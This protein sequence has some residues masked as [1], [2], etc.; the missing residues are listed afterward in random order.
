MTNP[1]LPYLG[2]GLGLRTQY[3]R[4]ILDTKPNIDWFEV[5]TENYLVEGGKPHYFLQEI[6]NL[7][8]IAMH[9][10]SLS[11]GGTDPLDLDYLNSLKKLIQQYQPLWV[12]DHLCWTG[13]NHNNSH[14]LLPLPY[15]EEALQHVCMRICKVQDMLNRPILIENV[16]SYVQF[17]HSEMTE[18][19]FLIEVVKNT[20]CY[21]LL[22]V[23]NV[24]VN[25]IN[26]HFDPLEFLESIPKD[27]VKQHHLAGH[28]DCQTYIIDTHDN[29]V[30][31]SVWD[32]YAVARRLYGPVSLIIER[33]GN[34]PP[35]SELLEELACARS[36]ADNVQ[37]QVKGLVDVG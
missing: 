31:K 1:E 23:N 17:K 34:M 7:Y 19:Q 10:V 11:I 20:G 9:G 3:V 6:S 29:R 14:D 21:L 25:S 36:I 15:T 26:H 8:P 27:F 22:D 32:L 18:W 24:Y 5:I 12:S 16:S 28:T 13:T 4:E 33:D 35:L 2:F 30:V 37:K